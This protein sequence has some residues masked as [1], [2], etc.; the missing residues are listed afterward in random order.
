M[1]SSRPPTARPSR[2]TLPPRIVTARLVL[3][4]WRR[5]DAPLLKSAIDANLDHLRPWMSWAG[6]EPSPLAAIELRIDKFDQSFRAESEWLYAVF[7][8]GEKMLYGA[9]GVHRS[10]ERGALEIGFWI[11]QGWTRQGFATEA[12]TALADAALALPGIDRVQIRCDVRNVASVAVA[13]RAGFRHVNT[14]DNDVHE[15]GATPR[16]TAVWELSRV[17]LA[18]P[19]TPVKRG[20]WARLKAF[21]R[22]R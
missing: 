16:N 18:P 2:I 6:K 4:P 11:G 3:R 20:F 15:R 19:V 12:V 22:G 5:T 13:R 14:L 17:A 10:T 8:A 1:P 7:S 21:F 9:A